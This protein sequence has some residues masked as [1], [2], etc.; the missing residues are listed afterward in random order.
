MADRF[1]SKC[2]D[3]DDRKVTEKN[4]NKKTEEKNEKG[5][6][7]K[8]GLVAGDTDQTDNGEGFALAA[9]MVSHAK[10]ALVCLPRNCGAKCEHGR[11]RS[12]PEAQNKLTTAFRGLIR[13]GDNWL[14]AASEGPSKGVGMSPSEA[15][16]QVDRN[17]SIM[18]RAQGAHL[19]GLKI[20]SKEKAL[21]SLESGRWFLDKRPLADDDSIVAMNRLLPP[22]LL[23]AIAA[24]SAECPNYEQYAREG[25]EPTSEG[26]YAFPFQRPSEE[27]RTYSVPAVEHI[28]YDEMPGVIGDPDLYQLFQNTWPNTVDTTVRWRGFAADNP[29]EELAFITT[30]DINAMWLR[31]SAN[32]LQS[33]KSII[34]P[35]TPPSDENNVAAL[36]RGAINLQARYITNAPFCNAFHPP[37]EANLGHAKRSIET[38]DTVQPK[39]DPDVVFECK[40]ELDSL[41]AFL[42]LSWDYYEETDDAVFFAK[43]GWVEAVRKILRVAEHMQEGTYAEDGQVQKP[44]YSWLRN[45]DSA[46][47][48]VSNHGHGAPVRGHIG[49]VRSFFRPSDDACIYQYFIPANMMFARYL[50]SCAEIMREIDDEVA[51]QMEKLAAGIEVGINQH[52]IIQHPTFGEMYA[53]E[54]D[55]FGSY[56]LMDDANL[57]SLLSIPHM[58]YRPASQHVYDNTRAFVLSSSNPYYARGPVLNATGGPHLGPG[59]AWPMGL[60]VQLLTSDDDDEIVD[61]IRQLMSSTSGLGL[62]HETV[63]SFNDNHWT[64][65]W[66]A[67][68]NGLFGQMI[69]DLWKRK[70]SLIAR[71]YQS[72]A[73]A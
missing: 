59:M 61:G 55:G 51:E 17:W 35:Y 6:Q 27:C 18:S 70:P 33:Y 15:D 2:H 71:S 36:F 8:Q 26:R 24:V 49:L 32:Q 30:G 60:I 9:W 69:L 48:T 3:R 13:R 42:Q 22:L 58:G 28:I 10:L 25:H 46:S 20:S 38:R 29:D 12:R 4:E 57:P 43:F 56:S 65:S 39:Y 16:A 63:N 47:E 73:D 50:T 23:A 67:W 53:Y 45:S 72:S 40:Y 14:D 7:E 64:R 5:E 52:A 62:I 68:A 66:F 37:P 19:H 44:A 21:V 11:D 41:A 31:D 34:S 1:C 54:I